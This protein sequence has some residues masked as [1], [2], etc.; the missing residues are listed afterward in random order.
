MNQETNTTPVD[1]GNDPAYARARERAEALQ[2]FYIHLLIYLVVNT[3]LF[4]INYVTTSGDG[5]WWFQWTLLGWG[6][7]LAV[8]TIVIVAPVFSNDWVDRKARRLQA[9][10]HH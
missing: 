2:G 7:G 3:G 5:G 6:I 4:L 1:S 10:S 8:H 9:R